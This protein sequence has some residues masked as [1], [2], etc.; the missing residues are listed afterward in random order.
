MFAVV[1]LLALV[2]AV[3]G[4]AT[5]RSYKDKDKDSEIAKAEVPEKEERVQ[6]PCASTATYARLKEVAFEEAVRIRNADPANLDTLAAHSVVRMENPVV[7]S[8]DEELNVT[9]CKGRF[10]LELP[11]GSEGGFGGERRLVADIEYAAQSAADGSGLVYQMS[12]AEPIIYR[13]ANFQ[14]RGPR[15]EPPADPLDDMEMAE[16]PEAPV[17][18]SPD[19]APAARLE[20]RPAP[21]APQPRA[22]PKAPAAPRPAPAP[23]AEP[24]EPVR[25]ATARPSFN[26]RYARTSG[27]KM[28]C[29]SE[30][31]AAKDRAMSSLFF[32]A[33]ADADRSTRIQLRR[34]RDRFL[35]YRDRCSSEGCVAEAYDGRMDEIRDIMAEAD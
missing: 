23:R 31:L 33:L 2:A 32:S 24:R 29:S 13:L 10:V 30:R 8:R 16:A 22:A 6:D 5:T 19:D 4:Y 14:L 15:R 17:A 26:C 20:P 7:K 12:G 21:S 28:V 35:A 9:V 27:E 18:P 11:P 1:G 3:I 34:T 25:T